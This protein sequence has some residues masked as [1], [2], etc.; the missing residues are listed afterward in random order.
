MR[1]LTQDEVIKKFIEKHG[2]KYDYSKVIYEKS[3][4]KV[5]II[6]KEHGEFWQTPAD[7]L[8]GYGCSKC[9]GR[10]ISNKLKYTAEVFKQKAFEVHGDRFDYTFFKFENSY[11]KGKIKCNTCKTIFKQRANAH[12]LGQGCPKCSA[13]KVGSYNKSN[14]QEFVK[15]AIDIY[16]NKNDYSKT[17]YKDS[18]TKVC[19]TCLIEGHGDFWVTPNNHLN[20][21]SNCPKCNFS[22]GELAIKAILEKNNIEYI[23][24][25]RIPE[26]V[27][28]Y[29]YDFYL[30]NCKTLIEFQ[31]IQHYEPIEYFGGEDNLSYIRRNDEIKKHLADR[32]KYR[33]LEF[34]YKQFKF[35]SKEQFEIFVKERINNVRYA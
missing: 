21:K 24:Q 12:L 19:I 1:K 15:K 2:D 4:S 7:H 17:E 14:T 16:G 13:K 29:E 20:K 32:Y 5:C 6:C 3:L 34:N 25:Y 9:K 8:T 27:N 35:M 11:S 28:R 31:G 22:K 23:Y 26:I 30:P 10:L 18:Y 33:L